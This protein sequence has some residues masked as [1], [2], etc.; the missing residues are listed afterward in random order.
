M[1]V[2]LIHFEKPYKHA[3][4][5]I[6]YADNID[7]R[8]K[9][10]RHNTGARLLQVVNAAGIKWEVVRVW[11]GAGRDFERRLKNAKDS[12]YFCPTCNADA[13]KHMVKT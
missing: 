6:G 1:C 12:D 10:H 13:L 4:H 3:R 9:H 7:A 11:E 5:Y 2:Y 8:I